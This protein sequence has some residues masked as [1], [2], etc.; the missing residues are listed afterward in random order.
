MQMVIDREGYWTP[1]WMTP[2][3]YPFL[4]LRKRS[5]LL[6]KVQNSNILLKIS[7]D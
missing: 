3:K 6:D 7:K 4:G 1:Y 2:I 5:K